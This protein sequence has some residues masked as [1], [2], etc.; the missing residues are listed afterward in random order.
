MRWAVYDLRRDP[1]SFDF[2]CFLVLAKYHGA[3]AVLFIPGTCERKEDQYDAK[4]QIE[5]VRN[6][7]FAACRIYGMKYVPGTPQEAKEIDVAW[8]PFYRAP[9]TQRNGYTMGW[10]RSMKAPEP[11]MPSKEALERAKAKLDGKRI[12]AH[13]RVCSY[14]Q[15]RNSS[16]DWQRWAED[17]NAYLVHDEP[18]ELEDRL[19]LMEA[20]E[21]NMGLN[22]GPMTLCWLSHRPFVM[23]K[24]VGGT[25]SSNKEFFEGQ[26]WRIGEQLPWSGKQQMI[27]WNDRDDYEAIEAGY[28]GWLANN[29]RDKELAQVSEIQQAAD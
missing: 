9:G 2:L 14:Q 19:A 26:G 29:P 5:R 27:V 28:Q 7:C 1:P 12:V 13:L 25:H 22:H 6:I 17:R 11:L 8:P 18:M 4:Q 3:E 24:M 10:L 21:L 16:V 23:L 20:A 15:Q